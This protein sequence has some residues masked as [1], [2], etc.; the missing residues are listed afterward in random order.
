VPVS[1]R[2]RNGGP[3]GQDDMPWLMG[4][5]P[6]TTSR[7]VKAQMMADWDARD[8][9]FRA[10]D[11][12]VRHGLLALAEADP[13]HEAALVGGGPDTALEAALA[14][15]APEGRRRKTLVLANGGDGE[16]MALMLDR[17]KR[18]FAI[19]RRDE[20]TP[21]DAEALDAALVEDADIAC[22]A[23]P[24]VE[25][26][27]GLLNPVAELCAVA[28]T[29]GRAVV[30]DATHGF[31]AV[32]C[33]A[34]NIDAMVV[35]P[36]RCLESVPGFAA[37]LVRRDALEA[38]RAAP[39]PLAL[40]IAARLPGGALHGHD[41]P[42]QAVAACAQAMRELDADGGPAGRLA[43]YGHTRAA[44]VEGMRNIGFEPLLESPSAAPVITAFPTPAGFDVPAFEESL[45]RRGYVI[46]AGALANRASFRVSVA[47]KLGERAIL[48]FLDAV[49]DALRR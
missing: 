41:A 28:R 4:P 10:L 15:I 26:A 35:A 12:R 48:G 46:G 25:P 11:A 34:G 8:P 27:S 20:A 42:P 13:G 44:L 18:P 5:G 6:V 40:D 45:R 2:W 9:L 30:V 1:K 36:H 29:R 16:R 49:R 37:L 33:P 38:A 23:L 31:G 43:R 17:L 32:P 14:A 24:L 3:D 39:P 21:F 19:A 7:A 22:L 47:G